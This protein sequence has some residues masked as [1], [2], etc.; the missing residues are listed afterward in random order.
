M[1][2]GSV[3]S[4]I[5]AASAAW[6]P[7]GWTPAWF[8]EIEPFPAAVLAHHHPTVSNEGDMLDLPVA[9]A[10]GEV[11]APDVLVGGTPCQSFS[12]AGLR[13]GLDDPRGQLTLTYVQLLDEIDYRRKQDGKP[14]AIAVWENVP[15]VLNTSCNAFGNFLAALAGEPDELQPPRGK[16][17]NAGCVRGPQRAIA[18]R[19]LDAQYF[20]LAQRR[21]RVFVVASAGDFDPA[22]ILFEFEGVRRDSEP[23]RKAQEKPAGKAGENTEVTGF[24]LVAFG[25][26][27]DDNTAS[28]MKARDYKDH[29]DLVAVVQNATRG[30]S[31]NGL[32]ISDGSDA[33]YTMD[34]ASQHA[35]AVATDGQN[36]SSLVRRL[37]PVE[38]ERLMGFPDNYTAIHF[39]GKPATDTPRYKALG[40]SMAVPVMRW[41]GERIN[42]KQKE[43]R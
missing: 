39:K 40:N 22:E 24:R 8:S 12:V 36:P 6:V 4:G 3:C 33:M 30:K 16:W 41:I 34:T 38:C 7:L 17:P 10:L 9:V 25:E 43:S 11:E 29:T 35:V 26:Y 1:M 15:A 5:E 2:F 20:G 18:W 42:A 13:K 31:Q 32:G 27:A 28:T 23:S 37:T 14:P 19:V 21:K